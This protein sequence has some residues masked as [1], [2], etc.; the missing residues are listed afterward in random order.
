MST[1]WIVELYGGNQFL[2]PWQ[3]DPGRTCLRSSAKRYKTEYAAKCA[4]ARAKWRFP[5]RDYSEAKVVTASPLE[6]SHD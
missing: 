3:G 2:A 4:L 5:N 6:V 1:E